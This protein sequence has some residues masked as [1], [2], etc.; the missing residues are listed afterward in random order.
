MTSAG[1]KLLVHDW[2][3]WMVAMTWQVALLVAFVALVDRLCGRRLWPQVRAALWTVILIKLLLPPTLS[4]PVSIAALVLPA[5]T[6][7]P[8]TPTALV[9]NVLGARSDAVLITFAT[10]WAVGALGLVI[11]SALRNCALARALA[12]DATTHAIPTWQRTLLVDCARRVGLRRIPRLVVTDRVTSPAIT[13][14]VRTRVLLPLS[15]VA[16]FSRE[17]LA[18]IF[19]HELMHVR[20]G[21]LWIEA[22][23]RLV[24]AAYWFH[25]LVAW[26]ARRASA[27]REMCCDA[28]VA[29]LLREATPAYRHT[30]LELAAQQFFARPSSTGIGV[31]GRGSDILARIERLERRPWRLGKWP[32]RAGCGAAFAAIV[33]LLPMSHSKEVSEHVGG[34]ENSM[35]S[36]SEVPIT[37][38][39]FAQEV[40][41][42]VANG[43]RDCVRLR[44]AL[45]AV[46]AEA[47]QRK[48]PGS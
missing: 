2:S 30:L 12:R 28:D 27:V 35:S 24:C 32:L 44:Y 4:S 42:G 47:N 21:D 36:V 25:P 34:A 14:L 15:S 26:A 43:Q 41:S 6:A 5:T 13:G 17:S 31:I 22:G 39:A 1:V 37:A 20:R 29:R 7:A 48:L 23:T 9:T 33:C 40:L 18:H 8:T 3:Q 11:L 19:L 38:R 46:Q 10:L 16:T 45:I